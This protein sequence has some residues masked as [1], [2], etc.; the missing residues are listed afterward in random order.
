[1]AKAQARMLTGGPW[2]GR[3][4]RLRSDGTTL[5]FT[6]NGLSGR[7]VNWKWEPKE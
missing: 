1:M 3:Y 2:A 5:P 6:L 7:Y 4:I